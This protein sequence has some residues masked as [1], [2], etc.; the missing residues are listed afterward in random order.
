VRPMGFGA[1][2]VVAT[3][4]GTLGCGAGTP[5]SGPI[6]SWTSNGVPM[7]ATVQ[8]LSWD[9][10]GQD[11]LLITAAGP[12]A[13]LVLSLSAPTPLSPGT[14]VC[15][16]TVGD[17]MVALSFASGAA[18]AVAADTCTVV[19]TQVGK[20]PDVPILGTLEA[21]FPQ[22][23]GGTLTFTNGRINIPLSVAP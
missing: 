20:T 1:I 5:T 11:T 21:T 16:Q 9:S 15:G 4:A 19:L 12:G 7:S 8:N 14:F 17:R 13:F 3:L 22:P 10:I 23:G 6:I 18:R 2:V